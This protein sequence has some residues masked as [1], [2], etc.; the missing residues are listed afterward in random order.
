MEFKSF[1]AQY[2]KTAPNTDITFQGDVMEKSFWNTFTR[3]LEMWYLHVCW[4]LDSFDFE[5]L[6]V[7]QFVDTGRRRREPANI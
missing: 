2:I 5:K 1:E 3:F 4:I 7:T 6:P